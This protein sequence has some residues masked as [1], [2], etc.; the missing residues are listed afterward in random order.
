MIWYANNAW[1]GQAKALRRLSGDALRDNAWF[2]QEKILRRIQA[3][4]VTSR[5]QA[6]YTDSTGTCDVVCDV[7]SVM[8]CEAIHKVGIFTMRGGNDASRHDTMT[9]LCYFI[10]HLGWWVG[11]CR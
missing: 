6:S 9:I 5:T 7:N 8:L 2:G 1:F 4:E 10:F 3:F 11:R